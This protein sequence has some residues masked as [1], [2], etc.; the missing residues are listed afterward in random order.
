[1]MEGNG[2]EGSDWEEYAD[3]GNDGRRMIGRGIMGEED[4]RRVIGGE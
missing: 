2:G 3:E 1:M 4:G